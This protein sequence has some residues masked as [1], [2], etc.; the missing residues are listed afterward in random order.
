MFRNSRSIKHLLLPLDGSKLAETAL[1]VAAYLAKTLRANITL[2]HI[3]E[4]NA[5]RAIHS[6][7]H[8]TSSDDA[9][10]YLKEVVGKTFPADVAV[11]QHVHDVEVKDV[12][13]SI[14]VHAE[15]LNPDLIVMCAHGNG[16]ARDWLLG[17]IAQQ[18]IS[19]GR[20][21][22]LLLPAHGTGQAEYNFRIALVPL[23]GVPEH[24]QGLPIAISLAQACGAVLHFMM[25]IPTMGK[26][27]GEQ[28][29]TASMSPGATRVLLE[30]AEQ[31]GRDYLAERLDQ[32]KGL[33]LSLS[34]EVARGDPVALIVA[35]AKRIAADLIIMGTHGKTGM[36]A[37]WSGSV[38]PKVSSR[39]QAPL[40]LVPVRKK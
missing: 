16:G 39:A 7:R 18:V 40:L 28:A 25:V 1:P 27:R 10:A 33:G 29:A 26:L 36:D 14:V 4:R 24:E 15:E 22:V 31:G 30:L 23:D 17:N 5:P 2:L 6:D 35:T 12:A 34:A 8:L 13:R 20:T 9:I 37:F 3:I 32:L 38:T 21:P 19:Q 11:E